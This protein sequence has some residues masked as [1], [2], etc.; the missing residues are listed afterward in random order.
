MGDV[1]VPHFGIHLSNKDFQEL[2]Q[3]IENSDE[4]SFLDAPYLRF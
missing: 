3:R 1:C 2:K 4:H